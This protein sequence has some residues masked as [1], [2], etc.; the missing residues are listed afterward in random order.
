MYAKFED[1]L[2]M[3][4]CLQQFLHVCKEKKKNMKKTEIGLFI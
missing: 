1:N 4:L 3:H 2:I